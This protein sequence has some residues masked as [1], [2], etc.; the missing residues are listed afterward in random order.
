[1]S[2]LTTDLSRLLEHSGEDHV[3]SDLQVEVKNEEL[4]V[5]KLYSYKALWIVR[6]PG[7]SKSIYSIEDGKW[8]IDILFKDK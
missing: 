8:K 2:S 6:F 5:A 7:L 3:A 4:L 1:M